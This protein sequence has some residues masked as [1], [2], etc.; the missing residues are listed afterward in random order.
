ML[1]MLIDLKWFDNDYWMIDKCHCLDSIRLTYGMFGDFKRSISN[2]FINNVPIEGN[3]LLW[4]MMND[5]MIYNLLMI[6]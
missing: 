1:W 5:S 6:I 2:R 3:A 4:L